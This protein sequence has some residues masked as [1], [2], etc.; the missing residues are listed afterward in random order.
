M[1]KE[2]RREVPA[3]LAER[4]SWN[5]TRGSRARHASVG[6]TWMRSVTTR[7]LEMMREERMAPYTI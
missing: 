3:V 5:A 1:G 6:G 2:G 4:T 7:D